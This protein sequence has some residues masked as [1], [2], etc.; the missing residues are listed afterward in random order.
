M[1]MISSVSIY[2][3]YKLTSGFVFDGLI[4]EPYNYFYVQRNIMHAI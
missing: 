1:I 2:S 4:S 3:S